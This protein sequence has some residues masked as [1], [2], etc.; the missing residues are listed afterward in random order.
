MEGILKM[1]SYLKLKYS[2]AKRFTRIA[3]LAL[4]AIMLAA[5]L[6][7]VSCKGKDEKGGTI[8]P[9][10]VIARIGDETITFALYSAAFDSYAAYFRQMGYDPLSNEKDLKDFQELV[11]NALLDDMVTLYHARQD[12]F[13]LS[14]EDEA[15]VREQAE[16]ELS[17]IRERYMMLA[18]EAVQ[19]DPSLNV[20]E[21][22]ETLIGGLSLYY[23]G[24]RM[25]FAEYSE[26]Y[27]KEMLDSKLIEE[28]RA[29]VVSEFSVSETEV[30]DWFNKQYESDEELYTEHPEQYK[31][32]WEYFVMYSG[33]REDAVPPVY[34]PEGYCFVHDIVVQPQG[35]LAAE[36]TG[37]M[38]RLAEIGDECSA[39]LFDDALNGT[40]A[41]AERISELL[42]EYRALKAETDE[43]YSEFTAGAREKIDGA[44]AELEAGVPFTEVMLKY[45]EDPLIVGSD[46][47]A[48]VPAFAESGR[49]I[50]LTHTS[51][52]DWSPTYK[53]IFGMTEAGSY[54]AVFADEDGSLH[55]LYRVG[56]VT[57]GRAELEPIRPAIETAV[58]N[59]KSQV[60]WDE[61]LDA[62]TD[63]PLIERNMDAV[64]SLRTVSDDA[65]LPGSFKWN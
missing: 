50:S 44:F 60:D 30:M 20:D 40:N 24:T 46:T 55:I 63:D 22:F 64:Y 28:Y 19:Q 9:D 7:A 37:K 10:T 11:F 49:L 27:T 4:A 56:E 42:E 57:P 61:L 17:E 53:E 35:E 33:E 14:A 47:V 38:E 29:H 6:T 65:A 21:Q 13:A 36:Y 16:E 41:N 3:S 48:A 31:P 1:Q 39:L 58:R 25:S 15:A 54:S 59:A 26:E 34:I 2:S 32:D 43:M 23:T 5:L 8:G 45:T 51:T 12:G 62:W 18:E 52:S